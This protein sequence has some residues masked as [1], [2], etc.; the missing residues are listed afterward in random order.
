[1]NGGIRT[2]YRPPWYYRINPK[3]QYAVDFSADSNVDRDN[4]TFPS[5]ALGAVIYSPTENLDLDVGVKAGLN[6]EADNYGLL[7]GATVRW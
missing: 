3:W 6:G 7:A 2:T 4:R 5:V 1:M